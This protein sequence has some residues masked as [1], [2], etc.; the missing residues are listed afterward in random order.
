[1]QTV[2]MYA[3]TPLDGAASGPLLFVVATGPTPTVGV[4]DVLS[5]APGTLHLAGAYVAHLLAG[6]ALLG[7]AAAVAAGA[8]VLLAEH[9]SRRARALAGVVA[10]V[11]HGRFAR[12]TAL[13][14]S[15][16]LTTTAVRRGVR[17]P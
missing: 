6:G 2:A 1:M 17:W 16:C 8:A 10:V 3:V 13:Q 12:T 7:S 5:L 11:T 15:G 4:V 9:G 14:G